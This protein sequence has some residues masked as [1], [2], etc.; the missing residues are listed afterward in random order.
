VTVVGSREVPDAD[1]PQRMVNEVTLQVVAKSGDHRPRTIVFGGPQEFVREQ[2]RQLRIFAGQLVA[3]TDC[4]F[5]VYDLA[6]A[7]KR[8]HQYSSC[9]LA[10]SPDASRVAFLELQHHFTPPQAT[11]S[12]LRV[13][14]VVSVATYTVFPEASKVG[15][16]GGPGSLLTTWEDDLAKVHDAAELHWSPDGKRLLFFCVH[17]LIGPDRAPQNQRAY[18]VTVELADLKQTRF[19]HQLIAKEQYQVAGA[20]PPKNSAPFFGDDVEWL[21]GGDAIRVTPPESRPWMKRDIVLKLPQ[22]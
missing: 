18:L 20:E 19:T 9:S 7:K 17:G 12:I 14:D 1:S 11:G 15:P 22:R 5:A 3:A 2:L 8:T 16:I 10:L 4:S 6:T 13:L 21:P